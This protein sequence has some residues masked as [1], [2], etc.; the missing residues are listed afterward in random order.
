MPTGSKRTTC[1]SAMTPSDLSRGLRALAA[2]WLGRVAKESRR[3]TGTGRRPSSVACLLA[4][5]YLDLGRCRSASRTAADVVRVERRPL[6]RGHLVEQD[7]RALQR[8]HPAQVI[9]R[10]HLLRVEVQM[11]LRD[12]RLAVVTHV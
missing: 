9:K 5:R 1:L 6:L 11:R 4:R 10:P 8:T 7:V 12:Q 2:D 3:E